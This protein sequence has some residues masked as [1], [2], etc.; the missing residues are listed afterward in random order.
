MLTMI[1]QIAINCPIQKVFSFIAQAENFPKWNYYLLSVT[2]T[3][4]GKPIIGATYHQTRIRDQQNFTITRYEEN[5][6]IEFSS[7]G[8]FLKY[9]RRF[10]FSPSGNG[11]IVDDLF[12]IRTYLPGFINR[13]IAKRPQAA[14]K[15]NLLK[16]K[17]LL[18]TGETTLQDG[19]TVI[20]H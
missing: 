16:L 12:Q 19:R 1:N 10:S 15:E 3:A 20:S 8:G 9:I 5:K 13:I 18:E 7:F 6:V 2:K 14:V 4:E 11:C 17:Q